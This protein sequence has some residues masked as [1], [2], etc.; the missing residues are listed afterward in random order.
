MKQDTITIDELVRQAEAIVL[1]YFQGSESSKDTIGNTQL[2]NA[3]DVIVQSKSVEVFCNWLRYQ[4][5]RESNDQKRFW[6]TKKGSR[7]TFGE[8]V[9]DEVRRP[10]CASNVENITHFLGFLRRAYIAREYLKQMEDS[11]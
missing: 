10:P 3:I 7:K 2:S 9:I 11:R 1:E 5:A 6:T 8:R 4:M